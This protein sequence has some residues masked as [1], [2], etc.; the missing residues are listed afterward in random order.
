MKNKN[1]PFVSVIIPMYNLDKY[2]LETLKSVLDQKCDCSYEIIVI[3][4]NSTDNSFKVVQDFSY[5]HAEIKL[6]HNELIKGVSGCRNTGLNN[7][8]GTW[9]AF[10]DGDDLWH[11]STISKKLAIAE[12]NPEIEFLSSGYIDWF[13]QESI[14]KSMQ[15]QSN[16]TPFIKN[17]KDN[18]FLIQSPVSSLIDCHQL[19]WTGTVFVKKSLTNK[20]GLFND[21][22]KM[23]QDRDYWLRLAAKTKYIAFITEDLS[24]YRKR[25]GS[26]TRRGI[27]GTVWMS[28]V[29]GNLIN[30]PEFTPYKSKISKNLS[31]YHLNNSYY[32]SHNKDYIYAFVEA[33]QSLRYNIRNTNS[34]KR[35]LASLLLR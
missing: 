1:K 27:P 31:E 15:Q 33:L 29:L 22:Y 7:A 16:I 9:V 21:T 23:S 10:L 17:T 28:K 24:W 11:E 20:I 8:Q 14:S 6:L 4:D 30:E 12:T 13:Y 19:A 3:D 25:S 18:Y 5:Q 34:Q 2:I 26:Q 32:Y 35:I